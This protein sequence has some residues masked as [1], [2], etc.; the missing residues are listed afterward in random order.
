LTEK[1]WD[2]I[3]AAHSSAFYFGTL[4]Q[5]DEESCRTLRKILSCCK[6][7]YVFFDINIRQNWFSREV[8]EQGLKACTILK[9]SREEAWVFGSLGLFNLKEGDFEDQKNY[10]FS[11]CRSLARDYDISTVLLTMDK[12]GAMVFDSK[13]DVF[14]FS[15]KPG[16]KVVSTVGA[17]DSFS[18]CFLYQ[19]LKGLPVEQCLNKAVLLSD[20]VVRHMEA[21]PDYSDVLIAALTK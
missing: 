18:A 11:L 21:V 20:Y 13:N 7:E 12:D 3:V 5:R 19:L 2:K 9:A 17:G 10:Y 6:F 14:H 16:S 4:A 8:V 15:D 1:Q